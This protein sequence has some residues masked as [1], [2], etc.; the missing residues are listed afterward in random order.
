M[1]LA[2]AVEA[3]GRGVQRGILTI[4]CQRHDVVDF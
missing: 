2:V 3:Q 4:R 1:E